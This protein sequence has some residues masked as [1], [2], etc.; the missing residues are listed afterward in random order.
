[1]RH[2]LI[3]C[4]ALIPEVATALQ[5]APQRMEEALALLASDRRV[6]AESVLLEI[7]REFPRYGPARLQLG[8]IYLEKEEWKEAERHLL[9]ATQANLP[10]MSLAWYLLGRA[11]LGAGD[12]LQAQECLRQ[13][14]LITPD[15]IPPR[16][17]LI[18]IAER[19]DDRWEALA[20][21]R[22]VMQGAPELPDRAELMARMALLARSMNALDLAECT[23]RE[24]I[25][26]QPADGSL[27]HLLAVILKDAGRVDEAL[28]ACQEA[29][30]RGF[31]EAPV[32]VTLGDLYYEKMLLSESIAA[33]GKAIE[34]DPGA[35]ESVASFALSSLTTEDYALLRQILE[36]HVRAHPDNPNTLYSL[37]V[38]HLRD[39]ALEEA[40]AALLHLRTLEP[41]HSQVHYNLSLVYT[42]EGNVTDA[43]LVMDRFRE[44]K[45]EEDAEWERRNVALARRRE[46]REL[47]SR[48]EAR[49]ALGIYMHFVDEG[50]T[51]T[52]DLLALGRLSAQAGEHEQALAWFE[53]ALQVEPYN[54]TGLEGMADAAAV[55][56]RKVLSQKC[57]HRLELLRSP[58][59]S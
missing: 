3:V 48:G 53:R 44:L 31:R 5:T 28:A 57:R 56:Q 30:D 59:S 47:E 21:Y 11:Y 35:A 52:S 33:L 32:Y 43:A 51:E 15:F 17:L 46:A 18:E 58:C 7:A 22:E 42:R 24:A 1:M 29:I 39:N 25:Q 23:V 12:D 20:Q 9:V 19:T 40:K 10:R 50:T 8:R 37:G 6:E 45:A 41:N 2:C 4:L 36:K 38:M 26:D 49:A 13:S 55:L 16:L 27:R 34:L 54:K 14:I